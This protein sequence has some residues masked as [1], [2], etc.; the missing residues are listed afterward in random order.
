MK[1][2]KVDVIAAAAIGV[3]LA[4]AFLFFNKEVKEYAFLKKQENRIAEELTVH[5]DTRRGLKGLEG[6]IEL[7]RTRLDE[8]DQRLPRRKEIDSFLRQICSVAEEAGLGIAMIK[9]RTLEE[10]DLYSR[11]PVQIEAEGTFT[12]F[13]RFIYK[14]DQ[15]PRLS[16]VESLAI[17]GSSDGS[18]KIRLDLS[19]FVSKEKRSITEWLK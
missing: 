1:I 5:K 10:E 13:Y 15:I 12:D 17:D 14:L 8:F 7:I 16:T 2:T 11:V 6:E 3:G 18:C 19:I 9:P 4:A